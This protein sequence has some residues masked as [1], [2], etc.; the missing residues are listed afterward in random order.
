MQGLPEKL[1]Y[2]RTVQFVPAMISASANNSDLVDLGAMQLRG[3]LLP[4]NWTTSDITFNGAT[5]AASDLNYLAYPI[6][7]FDG[8]NWSVLTIP[9]ATSQTWTPLIA[10]WF[11]AVPYVQIVSVTPQTDNVVIL[12]ALEPLYQGIHN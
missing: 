2:K 12:L 4:T 8:T 11:D 7:N 10:F 5:V 9:G 3:I 1:T 6:Q